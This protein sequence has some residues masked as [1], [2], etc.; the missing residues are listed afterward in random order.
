MA[1]YNGQR[2]PN[3][4][5]F[6][7]NLN[8]IPTAQ[9]MAGQG[10][11]D[12]SLDAELAMFTNTQFFDFDLGQDVELQQSSFDFNAQPAAGP[13]PVTDSSKSLDFPLGEPLFIRSIWSTIRLLIY[14]VTWG[15]I[16]FVG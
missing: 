6:I 14:I 4:S 10:Q 7:A 12:F 1:N 16:P 2:G 13:I 8:A 5:E 9:D 11:D 15:C 3:V